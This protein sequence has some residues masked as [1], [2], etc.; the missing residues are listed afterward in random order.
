MAEEKINQRKYTKPSAMR[1]SNSRQAFNDCLPGS[2]DTARCRAG[3]SAA[4]NCRSNGNAADANCRNTGNT[5]TGNCNTG[6][7]VV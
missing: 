1:L 2:S 7:G 6:N 4:G 5:A 3:S